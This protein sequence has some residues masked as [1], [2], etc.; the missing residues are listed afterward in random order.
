[1]L[2]GCPPAHTAADDIQHREHAG[3]GMVDALLLELREVAPAG[4]A[5]VDHGGHAAAESKP[6]GANAKLAGVLA[7]HRPGKDVDVHIDQPRDHQ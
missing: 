2:D 7:A 1:L 3:A 4:T 6:V 5:G